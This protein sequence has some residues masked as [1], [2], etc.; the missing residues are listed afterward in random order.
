MGKSS[1]T[2][3]QGAIRKKSKNGNRMN[4]KSKTLKKP[5]GKVHVPLERSPILEKRQI[6][7]INDKT[8]CELWISELKS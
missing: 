3:G 1:H 7:I 4:P 5:A 2:K 6:E 8:E